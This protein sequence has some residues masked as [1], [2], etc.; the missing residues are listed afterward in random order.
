MYL[1]YNVLA[2]ECTA[3]GLWLHRWCVCVCVSNW[4][5]IYSQLNVLHLRWYTPYL[6]QRHSEQIGCGQL[7]RTDFVFGI[8]SK[9]SLLRNVS[10]TV[11]IR[12]LLTY[13]KT[14]HFLYLYMCVRVC[15]CVCVCVYVCCLCTNMQLIYT[16]LSCRAARHF[17]KHIHTHTQLIRFQNGEHSHTY[18]RKH[19]LS[20]TRTHTHTHMHTYTHTHSYTNTH[21]QTH[22]RTNTHTQTHTHT[23]THTNTHTNTGDYR[24][25]IK[26]IEITPRIHTQTHTHTHTHTHTC[27]HT[28]VHTRTHTH[29][30]DHRVSAAVLLDIS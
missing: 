10:R 1:Q 25:F 16:C 27:T 9:V 17:I 11:N 19:T 8:V 29:T 23:H 5:S 22:T 13:W 21:T 18:T 4:N 20:H 24:H 30:V 3:F 7:T 28:H 26:H 15:V 14:E 6:R 2:I 12:W